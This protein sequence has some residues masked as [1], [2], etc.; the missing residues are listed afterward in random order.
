[1]LSSR[2]RFGWIVTIAFIA[3]TGLPSL[4]QSAGPNG[5]DVSNATV[6]RDRILRGGPARDAIPA[7]DSPETVS[8]EDAPWRDDD[9][10][11]GVLIGEEA[12]A[13]PIRLL[14]WHELVND[15]LGGRPLLVSYC[16]LCGSALVFDR[17]VAPRGGGDAHLLDFGVSG[18][19]YQSDLLM[20]DRQTESLWSQIGAHA[21][22]GPL[23]D[24]R[25]KLVHSRLEPWSKWRERHP[26]TTILS[27][28]T[29]HT[30]N[31][32]KTPYA[33]YA[34]SRQLYFPVPTDR[35]YHPKHRTLGVRMPDGRARAYPLSEVIRAGRRVD[36]RFAGHDLV[37]RVEPGSDSFDVEAPAAVDVIETYWFAWLA[38]HPDSSVYRASP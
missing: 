27:S 26:K 24:A 18:L 38:F 10:V 14:V 15:T 3:S 25:L 12:R 5:F 13:Y 9:W 11:V 37:I 23:R 35:R 6:P 31:Y 30:R 7:L 20:F 33:G 34:E 16:P 2:R 32:D 17:R 4:V 1:M 28:R 8:A 29:G 21:I 36:D 19:L 22:S